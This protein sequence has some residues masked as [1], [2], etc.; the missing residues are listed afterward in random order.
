MNNQVHCV[1]FCPLGGLPFTTVLQ[2]VQEQVYRTVL[3]TQGGASIS[4]STSY[5]KGLDLLFFCQLTV[6]KFP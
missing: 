4:C 1:K 3:P 2:V 6:G 5:K